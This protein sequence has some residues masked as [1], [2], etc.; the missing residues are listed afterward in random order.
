MSKLKDISKFIPRLKFPDY[1]VILTDFKGH[2]VKALQK[3]E[4]LS[5]Q[6]DLIFE[7]RDSRAPLSSKNVLL[8]RPFLKNKRQE[9]IILYSKRDLSSINI[10]KITKWHENLNES[11]MFIDCRSI[12]DS[13]NLIEICKNYYYNIK[14]TPPPLGLRMLIIGMP[15][16][17]KSTL[18]N[19]L[20][21]VGLNGTD[22]INR[23]KKIAKTGGQPGVT[24]NTSSIIKINQDPELLLYDTP[25][26]FLPKVNSSKTMIILSL[27]GAVNP[28]LVDPIIQ[29]DYLLYIINL[30]K[31]WSIYSDYL[32]YPTNDINL[33]L[34]KIGIKIGKFIRK[35][36]QIDEVG[37]AIHWINQ[38]K[39]G[40]FPKKKNVNSKIEP[41]NFEILESNIDDEFE[42]D[43]K[44]WIELERKR[45]DEMNI[46]LNN[47]GNIIQDDNDEMKKKKKKQLSYRE[48]T[49][50]NANQ[51][52]KN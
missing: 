5:P 41:I 1:N 37:T 49:S 43:L 39:Q 19:T 24:R 8:D 21:K 45:V 13:Q 15:N 6:L 25:G 14:P 16:V 34:N 42:I 50:I 40:K 27:I 3:M 32:S 7:I 35:K 30:Q 12:K 18:V 4:Q 46:K 23:D 26:V 28:T 17:G 44:Q 48:R 11:F 33:L 47:N 36:N 22:I 52:F 20:R 38:F 31:K 9:K 51:L 29:A 2:H 10:E